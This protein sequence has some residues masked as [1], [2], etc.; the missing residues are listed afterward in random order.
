MDSIAK[1]D[2]FT[3]IGVGPRLVADAAGKIVALISG[4]AC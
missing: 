2:K 4:H 3:D 1:P